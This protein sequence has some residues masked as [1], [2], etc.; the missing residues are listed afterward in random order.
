M[1]AVLFVCKKYMQKRTVY[2]KIS[3]S[4]FERG[5]NNEKSIALF[6][7]DCYDPVL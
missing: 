6:I 7:I 3:T 1:E 2:G 5:V 4:Y